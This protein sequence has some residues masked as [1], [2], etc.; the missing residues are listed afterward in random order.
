MKGGFRR[1]LCLD[2]TVCDGADDDVSRRVFYYVY[3]LLFVVFT[4]FAAPSYKKGAGRSGSVS[5]KP[6]VLN[7]TNYD[8]TTISTTFYYC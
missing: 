3:S 1:R 4:T 2:G 8:V 7:Y 5:F 6:V